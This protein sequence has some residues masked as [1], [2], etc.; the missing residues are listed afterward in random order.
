MARPGQSL[1]PRWGRHV[2]GRFFLFTGGIHVGIVATDAQAY[3]PF[4]DQALV[5]LVR[6]AWHDVFMAAPELWGLCLAAGEV[7]LGTLLLL[8]PRAAW[9]GWVGV[10]AFHLL[11]MLFSWGIWLWCVPA[12]VILNVLAIP[13][14]DA[15]L[16][17]R[18]RT[19]SPVGRAS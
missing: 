19:P 14:L 2:V 5:P 17:R 11:L 8:G 7:T 9:L 3:R 18:R 6:S 12:L 4:A 13:D 1:A 16:D 15:A 10:I